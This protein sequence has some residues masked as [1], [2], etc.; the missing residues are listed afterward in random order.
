MTHAPVDDNLTQAR[1]RRRRAAIVDAAERLFLDRGY[2]ATS[3][4]AIS[5]AAGGSKQSLYH[6]FPSK[7]AL[8]AAIMAGQDDTELEAT[9]ALLDAAPL[10]AL[11]RST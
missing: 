2:A 7:A 9:P 10:E 4:A 8:F 5:E 11:V 1:A 3:M 6:H